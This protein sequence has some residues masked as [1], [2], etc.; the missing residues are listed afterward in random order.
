[1][2][3]REDDKDLLGIWQEAT[4]QGDDGLRK[5]METAIQRILE[6]ELTSFLKCRIPREDAGPKGIPQRVQATGID[7]P[8]WSDG[9]ADA[10][11]PGR[12][13]S[14]GALRPVPEE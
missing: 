6:K 13:V 1:M 14:N 2:A 8:A 9:V 7:D 12:P 11:G 10:Q 3:R 5:V 4:G